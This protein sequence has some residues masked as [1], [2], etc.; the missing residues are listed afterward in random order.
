MDADKIVVHVMKR[1]RMHMVL[2][3]FEKHSSIGVKRRIDIL[4]VRFWRS[5]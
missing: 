4:M 3:F 5:M 1:D 2:I